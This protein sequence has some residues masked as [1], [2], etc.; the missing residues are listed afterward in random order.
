MLKVVIVYLQGSGGNL[1]ARSLAL[2]EHTIPFVTQESAAEQPQC[3]MSKRQRLLTY[4]NWNGQDWTQTE[5]QLGIWYHYGLANFIDYEESNLMLVDTFHPQAFI[6]ENTQQI[7]WS[8]LDVW[9]HRV[10]IDWENDDLEEIMLL[11]RIKRKDKHHIEQIKQRELAAFEQVK[12]WPNFH[13]IKWKDMLQ[14]DS[15]I[16]AVANLADKIDLELDKDL[17]SELW[18]SWK[19]QTDKIKLLNE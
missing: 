4:N 14:L 3:R 2:D 13:C 8:N 16:S 19:H 11:A 15:Y 12:Q 7:L 17:V 10:L 5:T 9:Q 6:D 1:L 18:V